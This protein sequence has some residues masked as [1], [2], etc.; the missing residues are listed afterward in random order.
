M[1]SIDFSE[2]LVRMTKYTVEGLV[3]ALVAL[4]LPS[5]QLTLQE[6]ILLALTAA[7]VFSILDLMAP[8]IASGTRL[9]VGLSTGVGLM[10]I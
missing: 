3:V 5:K 7:A 10:G 2:V 4:L 6:V 9:G 1:G 8:S